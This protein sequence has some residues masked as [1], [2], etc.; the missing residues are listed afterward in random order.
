MKS[1]L[2]LPV[3]VFLAAVFLAPAA[4]AADRAQVLRAIHQVENPTNVTR[5]GLHGELGSYQFR[6]GTWKMHT[7]EPFS[8]A[9]E[10]A[11]ADEVAAIHYEWIKRGLIRAG[12]EP[13]VFNIAMAWNGG[14]SAV[15]SRRA[16]ASSHRYAT[17]V[18]NLV[19]EAERR[20]IVAAAP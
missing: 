3:L 2:P 17:R 7:N 15:I 8:R 11:L 1:P 19:T 9:N 12:L 16:P 14:L 18:A 20:P 5:P 4:V 6:R 10:P 13:S